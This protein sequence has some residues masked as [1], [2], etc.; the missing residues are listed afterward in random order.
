MDIRDLVRKGCCTIG[1]IFNLDYSWEGGSHWVAGIVDLRRGDVCFFDSYGYKPLKLI[2]EW[3]ENCSSNLNKMALEG[4]W[5]NSDART[6]RIHSNELDWT[7]NQ[8]FT[9]TRSVPYTHTIQEG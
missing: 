3:L 7:S 4:T 9:V 1:I 5:A 6:L 2:E 8:S